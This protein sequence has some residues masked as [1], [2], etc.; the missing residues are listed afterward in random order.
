MLGPS[1]DFGTILANAI[2]GGYVARLD[3]GA[4]TIAA[5]IVIHITSTMQG[6][7]GIDGGGATLV[8]Q[9]TNGAPLIQIVVDAGVDLRYLTFSNF[10]I[11][12]TGK[13]GDGISILADGN[14]RWVYN[15]NISDVTVE[16]VGGYGL[17]MQGSVFE[18][19]VSNSWMN[20]NGLGGAYFAHSSGGGQVSAVRW[21][22]GGARHNDGSGIV[23]DNG[24]RDLVLDGA[25]LLANGSV[26]VSATQG[27]TAISNSTFDN[28]QGGGVWFQNYGNFNYNTFI[29]AGSQPVGI[30]GYL[31]GG[32]TMIG[33]TSAHTGLG[34]NPR[35]G[36]LEGSGEVLLMHQVGEVITGPE[37]S[38]RVSAPAISIGTNGVVIP[39]I[40]PVI[41]ETV[42]VGSVGTDPLEVALREA[43]ASQ[44][45]AHLTDASY[46]VTAPIVINVSQSSE[47]PIGID[48]GGA[49]IISNIDDGAP[50]F[51]IIVAAG[52]NIETLTLSNFSI[53]GNGGEG[54]GVRIVA[55]GADRSVRNLSVRNVNVEHVGG[56]GLDVIGNVQ[57][58]VFN[59]WMHGNAQGGAR[60]AHGSG[61]G[62]AT[63]LEWIGG[64]FRKNGVA[65]LILANGANDMTVEG[66]YFVENHG[67]GI[68]ALSGI[69]VV[70][71]SGFENN[72][73]AGA[74]V[75]AG[76]FIDDT[77]STY[78]PQTVAVAGNLNGGLISLLGVGSEYYGP[79]VD[80][81]L[82][83]NVQGSGTLAIAG[84]GNVIRGPDI[85]VTEGA[86]GL[87]T[88][89]ING[90][91]AGIPAA[92]NLVGT[93]S[94]DTLNGLLLADTL[95]GL[96][97]NDN[98]NGGAGVDTAVYSH[99]S[100]A[101]KIVVSS[102]SVAILDKQGDEGSDVLVDVERVQ[103][104]DRTLDLRWF[105]N[106][107]S[108]SAEEL[109]DL[110]GL[111]IAHFDRAPDA[112]GL[113]YW[114]SRMSDGMTL[115]EIARSFFVQ[116]EAIAEFPAGQSTIEFVT[117]VYHRV[118]GR[119][120]DAAGL[121]YWMND[122]LTGTV[123]KPEFM[124]A[125]INGANAPTG[126]LVDAQ[127]LTNK[128]TVGRYFAIE[129]GLS[130][131]EWARTVMAGVDGSMAS[132]TDALL[133]SDDY[134]SIAATMAGCQLV[135]ELVG[136]AT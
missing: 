90:D 113:F 131:V 34:P 114:A 33:N 132:V 31:V 96:G 91:P 39:S 13:E 124:L 70:Q 19:M 12:G 17:S 99:P 101:Y 55:D 105:S 135:V 98:L 50:V 65:G 107:L 29:S 127:Y 75:G 83:A 1:T 41:S 63:E 11:Q 110:T 119:D 118:L 81:T 73:G 67:P 68:H 44:T 46:T 88:Q 45:T 7:L 15:W 14:D 125:I 80:P 134:A 123:S 89:V 128:N 9:V 126:S 136:I 62:V 79:G 74:I 49:K 77:F 53:I 69:T 26:G 48:L 102:T 97:G 54:D 117:T 66:A 28:N 4:Y 112:V 115:Q 30:S 23:L 86:F 8:S 59:S 43:I 130:N 116:P 60:F 37:I 24:A 122:L 100:D 108:V 47:R 42:P 104:V 84:G 95:T 2:E 78:G 106:T 82:L 76:S 133:L 3:G 51:Q 58:T 94:G 71:G 61:G 120:P 20:G 25:L 5:P 6:A 18:G 36:N 21:F 22:G 103:F 85:V 38:T 27:I 129:E 121:A 52:V 35:L 87:G 56:V 16:H 10:N 40:S 64:G 72:Q 93:P 109:G 32:A 92:D 57:G 111:Y